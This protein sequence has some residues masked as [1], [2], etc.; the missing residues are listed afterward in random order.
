MIDLTGTWTIPFAASIA[1]LLTG[2]GL[3]FLLR[4]D[5]PFAEADSGTLAVQGGTEQASLI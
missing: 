1:L 5:H 3:A 2:A 4:P